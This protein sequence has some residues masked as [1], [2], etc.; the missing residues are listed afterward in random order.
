MD[1][2][3]AHAAN[4]FAAD[5]MKIFPVIFAAALLVGC[6]AP[7][8]APVAGIPNFAQVS[9]TNNV[10]RGGQFGADGLD[11][12]R[13][14]G[15]TRILKLNT[16]SESGF[17]DEASKVGILVRYSPISIEQQIGLK[18]IPM[19]DILAD[20]AFMQKGNCFVHCGSDARSQSEIDRKWN[21][22]GGQDRT[23][24]VCACYR[25]MVCGWSPAAAKQEM[26]QMGFHPV[27]HGLAEFFEDFR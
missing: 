23:G 27:L 18:P 6:H 12:L 20:L 13:A 2:Q 3:S 9:I 26:L 17:D 5:K 14:L 22:Q 19:A 15:I 25:V 10:W 16:H 21:I 1:G 7:A 8:P 11:K 24:M 4:Q